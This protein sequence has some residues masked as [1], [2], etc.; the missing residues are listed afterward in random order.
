MARRVLVVDDD[1]DIRTLL[2]DILLE[3]G[4]DVV[5]APD[6]QTALERAQERRPDL[7]VLDYQM[8]YLDG[9][10]FV[11]AYRQ[12][13]GPHAPIVLVTGAGDVV[14]SAEEIGAQGFLKKPFDLE[15]LIE[16]VQRFGPVESAAKS[17]LAAGGEAPARSSSA[18][19]GP[20]HDERQRRLRWMAG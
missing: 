5:T 11:A 2:A 9:P 16:M 19:A 7:I 10:R 18:L 13:P 4:W 3:E 14:E 8:P 17:A 15:E 1:H 6:G 12:L 20:Q